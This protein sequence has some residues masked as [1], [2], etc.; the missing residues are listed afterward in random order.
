MAVTENIDYIEIEGVAFKGIGWQGL[1]TVNTKTYVDTP[2]RANDG[3]IPNIDDH[4]TFIV[5]RAKV[6][7]KLFSIEEYQ[8]LCEIVTT[9]NQFRVKYWDKDLG[10]FVTHYMYCEPLEMK[11]LFNVGTYII[12]VLDYEVSFI[13]TLNEL[14]Q[15][16][17]EFYLNPSNDGSSI[18]SSTSIDWGR[19]VN[20]LDEDGLTEAANAAGY[21]IPSGT[22][23]CWNTRANGSGINYFPDRKRAN[24]YKSLK[25]YAQWEQE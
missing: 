1:L 5:P 17:V 9:F 23:K 4:D 22:F 15:L 16:T 13:G 6:N 11:K 21:T 19:Q 12:G 24:V 20:I 18:L 2:S 10:E 14:E 8:K 25:L 7:F 3:S